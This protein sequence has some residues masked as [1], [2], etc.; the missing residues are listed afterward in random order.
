MSAME[1][2][3][4]NGCIPSTIMTIRTIMDDALNQSFQVVILML[5]YSICM[6]FSYY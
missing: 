4:K 1:V 6:S 3:N 5:A 2:R